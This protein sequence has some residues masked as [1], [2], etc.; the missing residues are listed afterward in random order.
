MGA[1]KW[2]LRTVVVASMTI[3]AA[4]AAALDVPYLAGRVNDLAGLLSEGAKARLEEKLGRL[5]EQTGA[6]VAV[7]TIPSLEGD[8]IEDFSIR[9]VETWKLGREGEDDGV[10]VLIARDDRRMRIE[11]GYGLEAV[12]T[13]AQSRRIIDAVMTPRF[14]S[15]DFD[16]GVEAAVGAISGTILGEPGAI[17]EDSPQR[18]G[19]RGRSNPGALIFFLIFGLPFVGP[20]GGELAHVPLP[21][22]VLLRLSGGDLRCD[23]RR[24]RGRG[25]A[26]GLSIAPTDLA[27]GAVRRREPIARRR[28]LGSL[29]RWR[30]RRFRRR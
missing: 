6:Q 4:T 26:A 29:H 13:D 19:Q 1:A 22:P 5:E 10:L 9:V 18:A 24:S 11:V 17:P 28:L 21:G 2:F 27:E 14:R 7:L 8:P 16:G 23:R 3:V 20:G 30:R 12:L 15:G 25:L